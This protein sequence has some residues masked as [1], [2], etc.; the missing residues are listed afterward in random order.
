MFRG[1]TILGTSL[2]TFSLP[3]V[4]LKKISRAYCKSHLG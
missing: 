1:L 2:L 4:P 3:S